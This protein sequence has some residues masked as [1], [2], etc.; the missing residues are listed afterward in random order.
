MKLLH[1][2]IFFFLVFFL[3]I[4]KNIFFILENIFVNLLILSALCFFIEKKIKCRSCIK[5]FV[6]SL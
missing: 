2:K 1:V 5:Y 6:V 4:I 3:E